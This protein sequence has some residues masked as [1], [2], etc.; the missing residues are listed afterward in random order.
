MDDGG[1]PVMS[2]TVTA[3]PGGGS[4][5]VNAPATSCTITGLTNGTAYTFTVTATNAAGESVESDASTAV[6]PVAATTPTTTPTTGM[7]TAPAATGALATTGASS[8][9][10]LLGQLGLAALLGGVFLVVVGQ[11]RRRLG[12]V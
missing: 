1:T 4:C 10:I 9:P 3:G 12:S 8:S 7:T 2:Y 5:T 6:T 11:R